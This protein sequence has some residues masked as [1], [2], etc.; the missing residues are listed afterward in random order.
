MPVSLNQATRPQR[1]LFVGNLPPGT[2]GFE[3]MAFF[4]NAITLLGITKTPGRAPIV[5]CTVRAANPR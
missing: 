2:R 5:D 1:R 3:L 4:N